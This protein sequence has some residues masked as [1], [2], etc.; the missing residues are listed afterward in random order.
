MWYALLSRFMS[1]ADQPLAA[2]NDCCEIL[3]KNYK[4]IGV[5]HNALTWFGLGTP[6]D[7]YGN[8]DAEA[9]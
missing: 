4:K 2:H 7:T 3:P 5:L 1:S 9:L 6:W 8:I